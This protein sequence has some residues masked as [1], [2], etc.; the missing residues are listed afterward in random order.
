M[1]EREDGVGVGVDVGGR[2]KEMVKGERKR[3]I[4]LMEQFV[5]LCIFFN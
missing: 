1:E 2:T 5:N 3:V 4:E